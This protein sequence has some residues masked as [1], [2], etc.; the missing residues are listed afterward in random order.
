M[1]TTAA[2]DGFYD[3]C[4]ADLINYS[5]S[6]ADAS[7]KLAVHFAAVARKKALERKLVGSAVCYVYAMHLFDLL[8]PAQFV[9]V[10]D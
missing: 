7:D 8:Q 1:Q 6:D 2:V 10:A 3:Y 5:I 4:M 9:V